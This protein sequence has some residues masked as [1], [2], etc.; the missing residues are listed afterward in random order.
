[1]STGLVITKHFVKER[2]KVAAALGWM[3]GVVTI[4]SVYGY[5]VAYPN[6]TDRERLATSFAHDAGI[7]AV[8]GPAHSLETVAGFVAFRTLAV[9]PL[10]VGIW[11]A[12]TATKALRGNEDTG[13][14]EILVSAPISR[15]RATLSALRGIYLSLTITLLISCAALSATALISKD[16][17]VRSAL[18]FALCLV[19]SG[20]LFTSVGAVASQIVSTRRSAATI[21]GL[22]IGLA[23]LIRAVA[24]SSPSIAWVHW[25]S[26]LGWITSTA[27]LTQSHWL[28]LLLV[29]VTTIFCT[30]VAIQLSAE[31]DLTASLL[32]ERISRRNS[33]KIS[34]IT[35]L[36][37]KL[38][39]INIASWAA[40]FFFM[41]FA[42]GLVANGATKA[43]SG[44]SA[45]QKTFGA[46]GISKMSELFFGIIFL[47]LSSGLM[48]AANS[49]AA[50][51]REQENE[52][53][54]DHLLVSP[55]TRN[56]IY[57]SRI[58]VSTVGLT[59]IAASAGLGAFAGSSLRS[60]SL[61]IDDAL[62]AGLNMV[63]SSLVLFGVSLFVFGFFPRAVSIVGQS[64]LAWSFLL[65]LIGSSLKLNHFILDT[66]CLH[67]MAFAPAA[68]PRFGQNLLLLAIFAL[69][70]LLGL[71]G[72][73]R[74]DTAIG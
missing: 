34:S 31:R 33:R 59:L 16:F 53:Y 73:N 41:S 43:F 37:V 6:L 29:M 12:L 18:Y 32:P 51:F 42:F 22:V 27:P 26:P 1:M 66:S 35:S 36:W 13:Q 40:G 48:F 70:S 52:G 7:A 24:D 17:S 46:L 20:Y 21:T 47:M 30:F 61:G 4:S 44:S 28:G 55:K 9:I 49:H 71:V 57:L 25:L 38:Q 45:M 15:K 54:I 60:G 68:A 19:S 69:V 8:F 67:H 2:R 39:G 23:F 64:L 63:P 50:A 65:E 72:F 3:V 62:L 58:V 74:R 10:I 5:R 11:S 14:W 56:Q